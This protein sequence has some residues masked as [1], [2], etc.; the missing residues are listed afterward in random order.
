MRRSTAISLVLI[1]GGAVATAVTFNTHR[2]CTD[3]VTGQPVACA[4][5][6][7]GSHGW[8]SHTGYGGSSFASTSSSVARGGFGGAGAAHASA[9]S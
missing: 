4:T 9:G 2:R 6:S 5:S 8:S 1:G 7:G 3:P